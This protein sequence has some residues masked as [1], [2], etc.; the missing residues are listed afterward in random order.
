MPPL[1]FDVTIARPEPE[2]NDLNDLPAGCTVFMLIILS[3]SKEA[4]FWK[5]IIAPL[6]I[7]VSP[8]L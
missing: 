7:D 5:P 2:K 8:T 1:S 3:L 4:A 6:P